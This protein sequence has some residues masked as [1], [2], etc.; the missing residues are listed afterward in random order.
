MICPKCGAKLV[1]GTTVCPICGSKQRS[2]AS[3]GPGQEK[4]RQA[5]PARRTKTADKKSYQDEYETDEYEDDQYEENGYD[6]YED[7][8]EDYEYGYEKKKTGKWT[9]ILI[10]IIVTGI[11]IMGVLIALIVMLLQKQNN[12]P[13]VPQTV[14]QIQ[15]TPAGDAE[16][17]TE[18]SKKDTEE[19]ES[20][21]GGKQIKVD[22]N[23][24]ERNE[25]GVTLVEY[26]S[27]TVVASIPAEIGGYKVTRIGSHAFRNSSNTRYVAISKNVKTLETFSLY[28]LTELKEVFIPESVTEI[29]TYAFSHVDTCITPE[30]SFA[31]THMVRIADKVVYGNS[32]SIDPSNTG[33][34]VLPTS[35]T[36]GSNNQASAAPTPAPT[37]P[38]PALTDPTPAPTDPTPA[39]TDPSSTNPSQSDPSS[40]NP[41]QSD[42]SSTNPSQSDPLPTD[43]SQAESTPDTTESGSD[44]SSSESETEPSTPAERNEGSVLQD[45]QNASSGTVVD[46][47]YTV[48]GGDGTP[49]GFAVV[50]GA[51][52]SYSCWFNS[53][54]S[55]SVQLKAFDAS[56][57]AVTGRV[58]DLGA[59]LQYILTGGGT[60]SIYESDGHSYSV[61]ADLNGELNT[62]DMTLTGS[63]GVAY[64][65]VQDG[66]YYEY[67]A[68]Q[69]T[70]E[71]VAALSGGKEIL[72][73][74]DMTVGDTSSAVFW[75]RANDMIQIALPD[76]RYIN[77]WKIGNGL[78]LTAG[79]QITSGN[80]EI[81]NGSVSG[82]Y[83]GLE[84]IAPGTLPVP[85]TS[86][87]TIAEG[88]AASYDING[89]GTEESI[90]WTKEQNSDGLYSLVLSADGIECYRTSTTAASYTVELCDIDSSTPGY[91][92]VIYAT[93]GVSGN[94]L[95]IGDGAFSKTIS[96]QTGW[97]ILQGQGS[98]SE[99]GMSAGHLLT[100]VDGS[101]SFKI[102]AAN[103]IAGLSNSNYYVAVPFTA[104][105]EDTSQTEYD[106]VDMTGAG[107]AAL[108]RDVTVYSS[109]SLG[110]ES[111]TWT[112]GTAIVPRKLV[113]SEGSFFLYTEVPSAGYIQVDGNAIY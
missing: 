83:T 91:N 80:V 53:A 58:V 73:L 54:D 39:P 77:L 76:G 55:G 95:E 45:I 85:L 21:S 81:G 92:L 24:Y 60:T 31:S 10:A 63:S 87:I 49:V 57:S 105:A 99:V 48:M 17:Q 33:N 62:N 51:D 50:Q 56:V 67:A 40:A 74:I 6:D 28:D 96:L 35:P 19:E 3:A 20:E 26:N 14:E 29:L 41:S 27:N 1:S 103:P 107:S 5:A 46:F 111:Q 18:S 79:T 66:A 101:G 104:Y 13:Y 52:G 30:G 100:D 69:V 102:I 22:G 8:D 47:Q 25:D 23:V 78:S 43:P 42:P 93:G 4:G 9:G 64:L 12:K 88:A 32:L 68:S 86:M 36:S 44:Q 37:N 7:D 109:P 34:V 72:D 98:F 82:T 11:I 59:G 94:V 108:A 65:T 75:Y 106:I 84:S 70:R 97:G 112:A 38:T 15:T 113:Y 16:K 2:Q 61:F 89:D 71:Q 90:S 110:A